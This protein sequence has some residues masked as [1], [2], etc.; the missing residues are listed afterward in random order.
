MSAEGFSG[1]FVG[2]ARHLK[3][4]RGPRLSA[5]PA[6]STR[7]AGVGQICGVR[8]VVVVGAGG[9]GKSVFA[10]RLGEATGLPVV[11]LDKIFWRPGLLPISQDEW[12]AMQELLMAQPDWILDGDLG[13][14]DFIEPRLRAADT[15]VVLD[16]SRWRCAWRA[17]LDH[18]ETR[19]LA[20]ALDMATDV[21]TAVAGFHRSTVQR[22]GS[23]HPSEPT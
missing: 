14:Y 5:A 19:I 21:P 7:M 20:L 15:I 10:T 8:R 18:G 1:S 23:N 11:E 6:D 12:A 16:F 9:A 2:M 22:S 13:P 17:M 4:V 3:G